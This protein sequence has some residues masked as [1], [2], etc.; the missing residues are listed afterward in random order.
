MPQYRPAHTITVVAAGAIN[1]KRFVSFAGAQAGEGAAAIGVTQFGAKAAGRS[2][3]VVC[4]GTAVVESGG[5][6]SQG[7][8][9]SSDAEGKAVEAVAEGVINAIAMESASGEGLEVEVFLVSPVA[10]APAQG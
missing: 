6:F 2:C 7:D 3:E 4:L 1:P 9:L 10:K 5:A 8:E